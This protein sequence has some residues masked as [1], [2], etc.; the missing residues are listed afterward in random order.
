MSSTFWLVAV[1]LGLLAVV[2]SRGATWVRQLQ[3]DVES[4]LPFLSP[5]ARHIVV[6]QAALE[7]GFG[8]SPAY[9]AGHNLFNLTAGRYWTGNT[10][11]AGD[12]EYS[13]GGVASIVQKFRSYPSDRACLSDFW[14]FIGT[15][16]YN[17]ARAA[18][19]LGDASKYLAEL[20]AAGFFTL[21]LEQYRSRYAAVAAVIDKEPVA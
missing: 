3:A 6:A 14:A 15:P 21:P 5:G 11:E 17:A 13:A 1:A 12:L 10:I 20:Y 7:S 8:T 4:A 2:V 16:R 18:L 19:Q 9:R